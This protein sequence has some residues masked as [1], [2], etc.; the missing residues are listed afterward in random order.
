M[1]HRTATTAQPHAIHHFGRSTDR[2]AASVNAIRE[3]R[4]HQTIERAAAAIT[5]A[6]A[7]P[8]PAA[9]TLPQGGLPRPVGTEQA[10]DGAFGNL[11][12]SAIDGAKASEYTGQL[13]SLDGDHGLSNP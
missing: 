12:G 7:A 5:T 8:E 13:A 9:V 4:A 10:E 1:D 11:E 3:I 2:N 6:N